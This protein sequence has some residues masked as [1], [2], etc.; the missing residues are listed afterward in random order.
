M[1]LSFEME[2]ESTRTRLAA[3]GTVRAAAAV[4]TPPAPTTVDHYTAGLLTTGHA[5]L[6][7]ALAPVAELSEKG[8]GA[9]AV[10]VSAMEDAESVN[11]ASLKT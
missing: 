4:T 5:L 11:T 6:N 1:A 2:P 10:T 3:A 8:L 9:A 7:S